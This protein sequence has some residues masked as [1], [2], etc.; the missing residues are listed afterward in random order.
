MKLSTEVVDDVG[1]IRIRGEV[2]STEAPSL[3]D[4]AMDLLGDGA[5]SLV[6]DCR[7][8]A[9][10]DSA[11]LQVLVRAHQEA[12]AHGGTVTVR[13]PSAFTLRLLQ[14]VGLDTVLI[15]DGL[16]ESDSTVH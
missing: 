13:R 5:R 12:H 7:D 9:F 8:I 11:G 1:V 3:D 15:I 14:T 6:I 4:A 2:D 16:P 10:I